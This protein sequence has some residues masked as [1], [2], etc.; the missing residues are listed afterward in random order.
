MLNPDKIIIDKSLVP[1]EFSIELTGTRYKIRIDYNHLHDFFTATLIKGDEVLV[2]GEKIVYGEALFSGVFVNNG[3]YPAVDII[4]LDLSGGE[5][6]A[7][8]STLGE[9]VFLYLDNRAEALV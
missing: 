8:W 2:Y 4:P 7:S 5:D 6:T 3:D 1:Y 9:R